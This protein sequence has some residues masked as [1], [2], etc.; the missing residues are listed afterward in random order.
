[1]LLYCPTTLVSRQGLRDLWWYLEL[2]LGLN[3]AQG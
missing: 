2:V 3:P 1:M